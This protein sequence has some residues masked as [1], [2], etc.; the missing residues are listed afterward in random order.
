MGKRANQRFTRQIADEYREELQGFLLRRL[1]RSGLEAADIAQETFLRLLRVEHTAL[2]RKPRAY[3]YRI[4]VNVIRE[5]E[6]KEQNSPLQHAADI[7]AAEDRLA[8]PEDSAERVE[9]ASSLEAALD[10]LPE[11][12]RAALLLCKRD[13]KSYDEIA[14]QLGLSPHTVKRYLFLAVSHCRRHGWR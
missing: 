8:A 3:L 11:M 13:G 14:K 5:F 10:G 7:T 2:I 9:H 6:L 12:Q 1:A 4:A